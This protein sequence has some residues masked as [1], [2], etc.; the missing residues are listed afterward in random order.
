MKE[1]TDMSSCV[2]PGSFDPVTIG[3]MD[4]ISRASIVFDHV[5]VTVM[6]N[7]NKQGRISIADRI[8]ILKKACMRFPNVE[9]EQWN[10]LL[11]DYM[12]EHGEKIL[13]RGVRSCTEYE[14]EYVSALMNR[15]LNDQ[16][17]VSAE[18]LKI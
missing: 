10:G 16:F 7:M 13:I 11:A 6:I 4:V 17:A 8:R 9:V 3:H 18:T 15:K 14:H 5:R 12:R 1:G 2:F